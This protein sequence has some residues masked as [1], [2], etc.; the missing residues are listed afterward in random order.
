MSG[1]PHDRHQ[2]YK[3]QREERREA[4]HERHDRGGQDDYD[5]NDNYGSGHR[6]QRYHAGDD[7]DEPRRPQ[8]YQSQGY[9]QGRGYAP[10]TGPPS[11]AHNPSAFGSL[12][13]LDRGDFA[14]DADIDRMVT[15]G[16]LN[17]R[18]GRRGYGDQYSGAGGE[19]EDTYGRYDA[20]S[21]PPPGQGHRERANEHGRYDAPS[22]PPPGRGYQN[23]QGCESG[24]AY[25][26]SYGGGSDRQ[27]QYGAPQTQGRPQYDSPQG[28]TPGQGR[29][30]GNTPSGGFSASRDGEERYG[31]GY[32]GPPKDRDE[33]SRRGEAASY[34][35]QQ[36]TTGDRYAH[37]A[38]IAQEHGNDDPELY[39]RATQGLQEKI[40]SQAQSRRPR[41]DDEEE[42]YKTQVDAHRKAYGEDD[43]GPMDA[44]TIGAAAAME[45]FKQTAAS[46]APAGSFRA[47][48]ASGDSSSRPGRAA[49]EEEEEAE[50]ETT[51]G[52]CGC[53]WWV[54][55]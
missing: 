3:E 10:P 16:E 12:G 5:N 29:G 14:S 11:S 24:G 38:G 37:L 34:Y 53:L 47:G 32:G 26:S 31:S 19:R 13:G 55:R 1:F 33:P 44:D 7:D 51:T 18:S 50:E 28:P 41:R 4:R 48:K 35:N 54:A 39:R 9:G 46:N 17:E 8:S 36:G 52:A 6:G 15:S 25:G 23:Q 45:A 42:D 2:Q 21:G 43:H 22:G 49:R 30:Q 40:H 20:P 27:N